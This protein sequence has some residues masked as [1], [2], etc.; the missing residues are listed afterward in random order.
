MI[1]KIIDMRKAANLPEKITVLSIADK[2]IEDPLF[3]GIKT[4]S[5]ADIIKAR[6]D[7]LNALSECKAEGWIFSE[8]CYQHDETYVARG[9]RLLEN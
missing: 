2:T 7:L 3:S 1:K 5:T 4:A 9:Y 8:P 6:E